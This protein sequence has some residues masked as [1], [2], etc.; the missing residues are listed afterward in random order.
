MW[1]SRVIPSLLVSAALTS[2]VLTGTALAG[3]ERPFRIAGEGRDARKKIVPVETL[4]FEAQG[5]K[6]TMRHL[7]GASARSAIAS[8]LGRE[9]DLFPARTASSRGFLAFALEIDNGGSGDL[10]FEPGQGRLITNRSDAEFP[11]DYSSIHEVLSRAG[12]GAPTLEEVEKAVYARAISVRPG[13]AVRKL[14]V[15]PGPRDAGFKTLQIRVGALHLPAGDADASFRF[16]KFE[17]EP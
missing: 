9:I 5:V 16:R 11:L 12:S 6:L 3:K 2:L 10:L 17:I 7:D 14:L 1:R 15:Y 13:G 8:V 4:S